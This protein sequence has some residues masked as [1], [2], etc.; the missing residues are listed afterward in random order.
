MYNNYGF[1]RDL[2]LFRS[3]VRLSLQEVWEI[4][5]MVTALQRLARMRYPD[6]TMVEYGHPEPIGLYYPQE[7]MV[8]RPDGLA[9]LREVA[10]P[11]KKSKTIRLEAIPPSPV[12]MERPL[13]H[14][15]N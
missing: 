10:L 4:S 6:R 12:S 9:S 7:L 3:G 15:S 14:L 2:Y 5:D 13:R 11:E 1:F 8:R